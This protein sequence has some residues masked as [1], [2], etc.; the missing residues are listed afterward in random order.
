[1]KLYGKEGLIAFLPKGDLLPGQTL[2]L[3]KPCL[4][5]ISSTDSSTKTVQLSLHPSHKPL[6]S[7]QITNFEELDARNL[8]TPG[9]LMQVR[10]KK[11]LVNGVFVRFLKGFYGFIFKDHLNGDI[12]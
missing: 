7:S 5:F 3:H 12:S 6:I 4:F 2:S 9:S 8:L 10:V 11:V 1:M